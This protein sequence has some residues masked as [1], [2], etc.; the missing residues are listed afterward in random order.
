MHAAPKEML[1][2]C[3]RFAAAM[4]GWF[5]LPALA[6]CVSPAAIAAEPAVP[7]G[8]AAATAAAAPKPNSTAACMECHSDTE[9]FVRRDGKKISLFLDEKIPAASAHKS[10]ECIDCH[11]GFDG[12]QTPH[13]KPLVP[14]DC[15]GCHEDTGKKKHAFHPRLALAEIPQG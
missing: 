13:R 10:L 11:E 8:K 3:R 15:V 4:T 2:Q 1:T 12:D 14:V 5:C 6:L 9:L 7:V